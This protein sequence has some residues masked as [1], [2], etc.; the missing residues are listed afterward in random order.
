[1]A[2]F[3]CS[4]SSITES[5]A[6]FSGSFTGG[7]SSYSRS[8]YV[9]LNIDG[10]GQYQIT[11]S[12]VGGSNSSFS[13][14]ISG[15]DPD[16]TYYWDAQLGYIA[17]NTITWTNYTDSGKFTTDSE[18][19]NVKQWSWTSS[20]GSATAAQTRSAYNVLMG[21]VT[22]NNFNHK[23]WN[24]F[25]DKVSEM[26][27]AVT[28]YDWDVGNRNLAKSKCYV[29]KGDTL[30]AAI[31]NSV[32]YNIGSISSTGISDVDSGDKLTGYHIIHLADVLNDIIAS[33]S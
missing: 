24:D 8:R 33:N 27:L 16:T 17:N 11:S 13:K 30:S 4:F 1:M 31:Y 32:R 22:T 7:D 23:V 18:S 19:I 29:S 5:S 21:T 9:L 14:T 25:V 6:K 12:S 3:S 26:K 28:G 20:N 2:S 10:V 15:L